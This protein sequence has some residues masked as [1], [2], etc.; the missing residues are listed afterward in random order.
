MN[1]S[2]HFFMTMQ[3]CETGSV[4]AINV[5]ESCHMTQIPSEFRFL[6]PDLIKIINDNKK[7]ICNK[8][9]VI[10]V[11]GLQVSFMPIV[12]DIPIITNRVIS[13]EKAQ[14]HFCCN[15]N[16]LT[17]KPS[18]CN[19]IISWDGAQTII[20]DFTTGAVLNS[21]EYLNRV[22]NKANTAGTVYG[23]LSPVLL[24]NIWRVVVGN[25]PNSLVESNE[26]QFLQAVN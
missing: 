23:Y 24:D 25:K 8:G 1:Y 2:E 18:E 10:A 5:P 13:D 3:S 6:F 4:V 22:F 9:E 11:F 16:Y 15:L 12:S 7:R 20:V 21:I 17:V 14:Y 19:K 26:Q